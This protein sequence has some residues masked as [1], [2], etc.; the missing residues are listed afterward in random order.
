MGMQNKVPWYVGQ[1]FPM[2]VSK[3][4]FFHSVGFT[5]IINIKVIKCKEGFFFFWVQIIL[6][7]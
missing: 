3:Y 5:C 6:K 2:N 4:F 7:M 1:Q